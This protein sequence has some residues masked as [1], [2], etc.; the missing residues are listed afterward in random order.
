MNHRGVSHNSKRLSM[1]KEPSQLPPKPHIADNI[2]ANMLVK[3]STY[4]KRRDI[5]RHYAAIN[6]FLLAILKYIVFGKCRQCN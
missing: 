1:A 2:D 3:M 6:A 5:H 4:L